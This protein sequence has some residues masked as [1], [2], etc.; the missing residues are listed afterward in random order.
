MG[1]LENIAIFVKV[2]ER[3]SFSAAAEDFRL[4]GTM[5]G[6][7]IRSLEERLGTKLL[8]RTT[9]RQSLTEAGQLYYERCK[10]ILA[11]VAEAQSEVSDL[12]A[13]PRGRLKVL[14]QVSFGVHALTP[15][16]ADFIALYPDVSIDL[17]VS[18]RPVDMVEEG[19][20]IA[21]RIGE[22]ADSSLVARSL[23]PYRS[24]VCASPEYLQ[25]KGIP[26]HPMD[27]SIHSC[28][29]LAHPIANREW[30]LEAPEG[31]IH[32]PV[33]LTMTIN[34]GEALRKAALCGL[35][36]IMQPEVL[37]MGDIKEGRLVQILPEFSLPPKSMHLVTYRYQRPNSKIRT[38]IDFAIER[39]GSRK[40][41]NPVPQ[42]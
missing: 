15:A 21:F 7:H 1:Q 11:E 41:V 38:F 26:V 24:I 5:V 33:S 27:L 9:R 30:K 40:K 39:F 42:K 12:Q 28:L 31:T 36:I 16:C 18:D 13:T 19:I 35:G 20:D 23:I 32:V 37:L 2:V 8:N 3:G 22:L 10:R 25:R 17:V 14:S 4:T 29:G 6:I 34:N